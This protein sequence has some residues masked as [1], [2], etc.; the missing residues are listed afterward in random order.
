MATVTILGAGVMGSAMAMPLADRGHTVRLVGTHLDSAIIDSVKASGRHP[1]LALQLPP[2]VT[3]FQHT[4]LAAA[5]A[6]DTEI[7]LLGVAAAGVPWAIDRICE[8]VHRPLTVLMI[9]KGIAPKFDHLAALPDEVAAQVKARTGIAHRLAAIGGPCIAGELAARR[10]TAT[11]IAA[12]EAG[13]AAELCELLATGY[14]HPRASTDLI[15]VELCAAFKNFFA[16]AVGWAAGRLEQEP[17][18]E[19]GALNHNAAAI[20]FDQ[21][22][23]EMMVLVRHHGG[24]DT[25][26]W[27]MPGA[28]DLYVTCQAGRNSRLGRHLGAGLTFAQVKAGPMKDDT[29]EGAETGIAAAQTLRGL[30]ASGAI[31]PADLPLT[32]ALL[33]ALTANAPLTIPW[34]R[35][36]RYA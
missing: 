32:T 5:I 1:R 2:G 13:L 24:T 29:I 18:A 10:Q 20:I 14:Y 26:V 8:S 21:A 30:M 31:T 4:G 11:T 34:D 35:L 3:G 19:N 28:G 27:G 6:G 36:H 22:I 15:G 16:I 23:A 9:T 12:R 33:D 25:S 7:L 17:K